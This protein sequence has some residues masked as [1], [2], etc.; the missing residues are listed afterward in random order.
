MNFKFKEIRDAKDT[1]LKVLHSNDI[2]D[3][4][5]S[6]AIGELEPELKKAIELLDKGVN[7]V[8]KPYLELASGR[9]SKLYPQGMN[10]QLELMDLNEKMETE[11][12]KICPTPLKFPELKDDTIKAMYKSEDEKLRLSS[13]D[14][15]KLKE[16]G[17]MA[18][19]EKK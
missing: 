13:Y 2:K 16:L 14:L 18:K 4:D 3:F 7:V 8:R 19:K 17:L 11:L 6:I 5:D 9:T 1:L 15:R 10:T 12:D